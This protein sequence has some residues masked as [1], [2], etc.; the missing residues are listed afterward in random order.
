MHFVLLNY[1]L[2]SRETN[3]PLALCPTQMPLVTNDLIIFWNLFRFILS[4]LYCDKIKIKM[5]HHIKNSAF[6]D[7][8]SLQ[9]W[10]TLH[11]NGFPRYAVE[12]PQAFIVSR[13]Y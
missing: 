1:F 5:K 8:V 13:E 11:F 12:T 7:I 10:N 3:L 4:W 6:E 2:S 9:F